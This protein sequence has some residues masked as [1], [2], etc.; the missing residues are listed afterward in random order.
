MTDPARP[1]YAYLARRSRMTSDTASTSWGHAPSAAVLAF[2]FLAGYAVSIAPL[3]RQLVAVA[4]I[5]ICFALYWMWM[6]DGRPPALWDNEP[7]ADTMPYQLRYEIEGVDE[8]FIQDFEEW[9]A[10]YLG[11]RIQ[12]G[13]R[14]QDDGEWSGRLVL[15]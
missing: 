12:D 4:A 14:R 13:T 3:P 7:G 9:A 10:Q 11:C 1:R 5:T 2:I 15:R 6:E 8:R